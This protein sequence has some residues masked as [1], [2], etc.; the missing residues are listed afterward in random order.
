VFFGSK[1]TIKPLPFPVYFV[2]LLAL[3]LGGLADS[4]YLAISHYRVYTDIDY[5]SFC[6][7]SKSI[8]CD[9]VSQSPYSILLGVPVPLW[10]VLGYLVFSLLLGLAWRERWRQKD[11]WALLHSIALLF[12]LYSLVLAFI[13]TYYVHSYCIMCILSYGINLLLLFYTWLIRKR[14]RLPNLLTGLGRD[15]RL[16]WRNLGTRTACLALPLFVM[17]AI[18]AFPPYWSYPEPLP[19]ESLQT[20]MTEDGHP[21]IG[22]IHPELEITEYTD[23]LCFQCRK[24]HRYL[25]KLVARYP[26]RIRLVHRHFPMDHAFNPLVKEPFH[27]GSG[28]MAILAI[29]AAEQGRFWQMNDALFDLGHER[30]KLDLRELSKRTGVDLKGMRRALV[31]RKDLE[32]KLA[33]DIWAGMKLEINGTPAYVIDGNVYLAQIPPEIFRKVMRKNHDVPTLSHGSKS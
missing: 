23:Y 26:N 31:A 4:I 1:K 25:R 21:W 5:S 12:S 17:L 6:A 3:A 30:V 28:K 2:P 13:S 18:P 10:G 11:G 15:V 7:L 32:M 33:K 22:A 8:N 14:F 27:V 20:G 29:F 19:I 16:I 9:T 24:M